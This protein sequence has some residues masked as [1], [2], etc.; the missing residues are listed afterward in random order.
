[1]PDSLAALEYAQRDIDTSTN[2]L[3]WTTSDGSTLLPTQ[4]QTHGATSSS[5]LSSRSSTD[6]GT[7]SQPSTSSGLTTDSQ[8]PG[9]GSGS[10]SGAGTIPATSTSFITGLSGSSSFISTTIITSIP[11]TITSP[12][13]TITTNVPTTITTSTGIL[14]SQTAVG[15]AG[16]AVV[17]GQPVCIGDGVDIQAVGLLSTLVLPS[18]IGLIIWLIFA[19]LR[20]HFRQVYAV[21]EWFPPQELRSQPLRDTLWAFLFP[22]VPFVPSIPDK[23]ELSKAGAGAELPSDGQLSQRVLWICFLIALGWSLLGLLGALPLYLV[24]TPC[25]EQSFPQTPFGG[26]YSTLQDLS[27]LRLLQL[28]ENNDIS[29]SSRAVSRALVNGVDVNPNIRTRLIILTVFVLVLAM[30]PALIKLMKEF[31]KLANYRRHWL[32]VR[33]EGLEMGWL[34]AQKAP[35]FVGWGEKR[36]KDFITKEGLSSSL[37]KNGGGISASGNMV[38]IGS[39][40]R[41]R[42]TS[43]RNRERNDRPSNDDEKQELEVDIRSLFSVGDTGILPSLIQERDRILDQLEMAEARYIASFK[44]MTPDPSSAELPLPPDDENNTKLRISRP[45]AL[46]GYQRSRSRRG[47]RKASGSSTA[48]TSFVAPSQYYKLRNIRGISGGRIYSQSGDD[49][50]TEGPS[51]GDSVRSRIVGSRFQEF[52][53]E[54]GGEPLPIGSR[55]T[56]N[57]GELEPMTQEQVDAYGPRHG[58][59]P[60]SGNEADV[61]TVPLT[62]S[63][64]P[65]TSRG[66]SRADNGSPSTVLVDSV[67]HY[68]SSPGPDSGAEDVT[69]SRARH[70]PPK[71]PVERRETFAMRTP[72][73][74]VQNE[75]QVPLHLRLQSQGPFVRPLSGLDHDFLGAVYS[76]VRELRTRL[77][78]INAEI[79]EVQND[80]YNDIADGARIKGWLITGRGVR[81]LPGIELIEGRSKDDILWDELQHEGRTEKRISFWSFVVMVTVLLGAGLVGVAGLAVSTAPNVAHYLPFFGPFINASEKIGPGIAITL[82][83]AI[84]ATL[85]FFTAIKAVKRAS[86][87]S[88]DI[89]VTSARL[90]TYKATF[91]ILCVI[92]VMWLTAVGAVVF[93][94]RAFATSSARPSSV[95]SG[96]IYMSAFFLALVVNFAIVAPGLLLLQPFRLKNVLWRE[97]QAITPRQRFRALYPRPYDPTYATACCILAIILAS[98]FALIFPFIGPAVV[99]LLLLTIVAHR[100]LVGYVYGR[101]DAQT[102]GLLQIWLL[103]RFAS[104]TSFQPILLG[105]IF[106]TRRLFVEGGILIGVGVAAM[107]TVEVYA[108]WKTRLPG[109]KSLT[110]KTLNSLERFAGQARPAGKQSVSETEGSNAL[111]NAP[112]MRS[113]G[114]LASVLEMMSLTLAVM[115]TPHQARGAVPIAETESLDDLTATDRAARTHP[116]APPHLPPLPFADHAEEMAGILYASEL[117]APAPTIWLPNDSA[118]IARSEAYD[119]SR[120]HG[121]RTT[122]DVR[123]HDDVVNPRRRSSSRHRAAT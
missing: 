25:L 111:V 66:V 97:R 87:Y 96:S 88:G 51:F 76:D 4:S 23:S 83:P 49:S 54:H 69:P 6:A 41:A 40:Y 90:T 93:A 121:L 98:T 72:G 77:K 56:L 44:L 15:D 28:L 11:S 52:S 99:L 110:D 45:K 89:S 73:N 1:M 5:H 43:Q 8:I 123:S 47:R 24:T 26:L 94:M 36:I 35:G 75:G 57:Q 82:V 14:V 33:C 62:D 32:D 39:G 109:R 112:R 70:V 10:S 31:T 13:T 102:G 60:S 71:Y 119:L 116:D 105:L 2:G 84:L 86:Q 103:K 101:T 20:P 78:Q 68:D 64:G 7:D 67:M 34:S 108:Y 21:R 100:F 95:A 30:L 18:V 115:P 81:F 63:A 42:T 50:F 59:D 120:Y 29:T 61:E 55:V 117:I 17:A 80:C 19:L 27:V 74:E 91:F 113:R 65:E 79:S 85:F 118:G 16:S 122:I 38:G 37:D 106:L 9:S 53:S 92:G 114:S 46:A 12:S 48:P 22:H 3:W 104:I 58:M 107:A